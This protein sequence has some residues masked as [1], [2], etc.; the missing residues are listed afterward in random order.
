MYM[1]F[2][3]DYLLPSEVSAFKERHLPSIRSFI[4]CKIKD[5]IDCLE[6]TTGKYSPNLLECGE[7]LAKCTERSIYELI[8]KYLV[9]E[10]LIENIEYVHGNNSLDFRCELEEY[11]NYCRNNNHV[12]I[13]NTQIRDILTA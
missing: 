12:T 2:R 9:F 3:R 13:H 10:F 7:D 1:P 6:S 5:A 8:Y 4:R 11:E